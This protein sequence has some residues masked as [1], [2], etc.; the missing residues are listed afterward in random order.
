MAKKGFTLIE[1]LIA[2]A[3]IGIVAVIAIPNLLS[4]LQKSKLKATMGDMK[5]IAT[6]VESYLTD[7]SM[8]PGGGAL[9]R[10]ADLNPYLA[11]FHIKILPFQDGWGGMLRYQSGPVGAQQALYSVISYGRDNMDSGMDI[12][13]SHYVITSMTGFD[14]DIC[15]ANGLFTY[16]PKIR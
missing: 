14:N 13:N 5:S 1:L 4:A 7:N 6:A 15:F 11:P 16:A 8:A 9:A 12:N 10:I 2:V 3:I